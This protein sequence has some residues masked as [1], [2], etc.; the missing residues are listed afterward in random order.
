MKHQTYFNT[1]YEYEA[2]ICNTTDELCVNC[3]GSVSVS[4]RVHTRCS[5]HDYYIM[6]MTEGNMLVRLDNTETT[7]AEG[8]LLIIKPETEYE[9]ISDENKPINYLW[10][11]F[12]GKRAGEL[13]SE[14]GLEVNEVQNVG[15]HSRLADSWCRMFYEFIMN[16][17]F[18]KENSICILKEIL[19]AFSRYKNDKSRSR[20]VLKSII[21]IHEHYS[22][23]LTVEQL[24]EM[25]GLSRAHYR[26]CFREAAGVS[27]KEYI[28]DRRIEAACAIL[29]EQD[30]SIQETAQLV[31]YSDVYYFGRIFKK[32]MGIS[33]GK[34]RKNN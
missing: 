17:R 23:D 7:I 8:Q 16:D 9:Y 3:A 2:N 28:I 20:R 10:I 12:S 4:R 14:Y 18:F 32:K 30:R 24:A 11:H 1:K 31:G 5:R 21:Y 33:P 34:Y 26:T 15:V 27:P 22:E 29:E 13:I 25:E 19:A 6:Y